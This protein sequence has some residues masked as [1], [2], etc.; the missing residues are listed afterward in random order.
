MRSWVSGV[1]MVFLFKENPSGHN[2]L[3]LVDGHKWTYFKCY[4]D[5]ICDL[6]GQQGQKEMVLAGFFP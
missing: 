3:F 1:H 5:S 4:R 6:A 2:I